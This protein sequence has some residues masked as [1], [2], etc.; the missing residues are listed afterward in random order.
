MLKFTNEENCC[1]LGCKAI[2]W[3]CGNY[4]YKFQFRLPELLNMDT[5]NNEHIYIGQK[6]KCFVGYMK[7][8]LD[9]AGFFRRLPRML[10]LAVHFCVLK[11]FC[12]L[13]TMLMAGIKSSFSNEN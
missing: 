6:A 9:I 10:L 13:L 1:L 11:S 12:V 4:D 5:L 8:S 2:D 7:V 3:T